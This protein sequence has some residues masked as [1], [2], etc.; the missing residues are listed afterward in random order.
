MSDF[1]VPALAGLDPY[2]PGEQPQNREYVKLN[3]NENPYPP[4]PRVLDALSRAQ[5]ERLNLYSDPTAAPLKRAIADAYGLRPENVFC[6]NGSDEVL[7]FSFLAFA[8][9]THPVTIPEVSYGF[10]QV[11]AQLFRVPPRVIPLNEDFT[12]PVERFAKADTMV[13]FANPNAPT[14]ISL[15]LEDVERI[16]RENE[17]HIVLVDEAY[18]DFG[19]QTALGLL[20]AHPNLLIVRTFSKSR[21]LAGARLGYALA[22]PPVIAD[23]ERVRNSFHPYNINRLSMLAGVEAM[24]DTAYFESCTQKIIAQREETAR[25]LRAL[26]FTMTES[27]ANFLFAAHPALTAREYYAALKERGVLVR[28]WDDANLKEHVRISIGTREQMRRLVL[29]TRAILNERKI[30]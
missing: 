8:D 10:Y 22:N 12:L 30:P 3:T 18:V 14:G 9:E 5:V 2:A 1:L 4:S 28:C 26:G 21:S 19:G 17:G 11:F 23:L 20:K 25:E 13:V 7:G 16:V 24:R 29:E 6:G 15:P 27:A